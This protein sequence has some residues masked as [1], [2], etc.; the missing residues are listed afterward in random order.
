MKPLRS[1]DVARGIDDDGHAHFQSSKTCCGIANT[2]LLGRGHAAGLTHGGPRAGTYI[3]AEWRVAGDGVLAC[4][5]A[6]FAVGA[7]VTLAV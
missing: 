7:D 4:L 6:H 5:I 2:A 1:E 3:T